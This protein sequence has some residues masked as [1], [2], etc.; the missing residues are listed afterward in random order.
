VIEDTIQATKGEKAS[1]VVLSCE[2]YDVHTIS[3]CQA[4][5]GY[6][7]NYGTALIE[8]INNPL[9]GFDSCSTEIHA[10]YHNPGHKSIF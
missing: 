7:Y 4:R 5:K 1:I 10:L 8:V 6:L 2:S 9:I 3:T